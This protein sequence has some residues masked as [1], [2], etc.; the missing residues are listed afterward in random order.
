MR[1]FSFFTAARLTNKRRSSKRVFQ[2]EPL[3]DRALPSGNSISGFVFQDANNSGLYQPGD[4]P[5]GNVA[6]TLVNASNTVVGTT[7][8]AADGSYSFNI[9][10]TISTA[11]G[12]GSRGSSPA[13][14]EV[15]SEAEASFERGAEAPRGLKPALHLAHRA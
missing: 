15:A 8:T 5:I 4:T 12:T 9:D 1:L 6:I 3:E 11:P 2:V 13:A 10:S 14:A 7:T